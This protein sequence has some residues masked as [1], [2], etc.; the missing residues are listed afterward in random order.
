MIAHTMLCGECKEYDVGVGCDDCN[1]WYHEDCQV[2][3][4]DDD[5]PWFCDICD[6]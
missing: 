5:E 4:V 2:N 3:P 1:N 6:P